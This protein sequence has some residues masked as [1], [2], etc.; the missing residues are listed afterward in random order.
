MSASVNTRRDFLKTAGFSASV[1]AVSGCMPLREQ[2]PPSAIEP[3]K[4]P[5]NILWITCEDI[6]PFLGCYGDTNARTPNID[7]LAGESLLYTKAFVTAPVCAPVRSAL[8]TGVHA[9]SLGT[10]HLRSEV[11]LPEQIRC[12]PQFLRSAGY[13]CT[14]NYKKDYNFID[15]DVWDES[16]HEAHWHGRSGDQ[17]FFSVFNFV[18]THQGQINGSD[19]EF[20]DKYSSKLEPHERH[21]PD[22][23]SFPPYYPD[24]PF[25][26]KIWARYYNLITFMDKQ[27]ADLLAQLAADSLADNTI[28]FFF[29][30]HGL[31]IPRFKRTLYDTGLHVPL[32]IRF[33][34]R[35]QSLSPGRPGR[36]IDRL[37]SSVD[38]APTVL[39][40]L[41]LPIPDYIQG[42]AFAGKKAGPAREY[43]FAAASRVDEAYEFSRCVRDERYK[44]I[45]NFMPHLPYIPP[46]E[47]PDRAEIMKELRRAAAEDDL[48]KAQR[49]LWAPTK[50]VEELY[51]TL[52]DPHEIENLVDSAQHAR[53]LERLRGVL[54][55]WM[56][57]T[58]DTG[59][60]PEAEM[61]IRAEGSTPYEMAH[62]SRKYAQRRIFA[63]ADLVGKGSKNLPRL[64]RLLS[65]SDSAARYWAVIGLTAMG[66]EA[67][68]AADSLA[69]LLE[70]PAPNV[71]FAAAGALCK[72]DSCEDALP[73][74]AA[75]LEDERQET[76][77]YAARELQSIGEKASAIVPQMEQARAKYLKADGTPINNNHAMFIDWAL[78]HAIENCRQ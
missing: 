20:F 28:V 8:V 2:A 78:M 64:T 21:D 66:R 24:T 10:Q 32:I 46:S 63:A 12:F 69:A 41:G 17:P 27:V 74:L 52:A 61:H 14:N 3:P 73:V 33:P 26:R 7:K 19:E 1:F 60:L 58:R 15:V 57:R 70:D 51:D 18:S 16:S 77:L 6:S 11:K 38:F 34:A 4:G 45:R 49:A 31:G 56:L 47:Y 54:R 37:V 13:Y 36:K 25:V 48:S 23:L 29:S 55:K 68:P 44:Y 50:P 35:Y 65:D 72:L 43:I 71:R 59:L 76:V 5:P 53:T 67:E 75:G 62:S 42:T 22:K 40:L 39:S 30:D 9:T